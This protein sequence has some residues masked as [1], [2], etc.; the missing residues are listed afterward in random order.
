MDAALVFVIVEET[1]TGFEIFVDL[2]DRSE[3]EDVR[4]GIAVVFTMA[5][6]GTALAFLI[7]LDSG[8]STP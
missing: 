4:I 1:E 2:H 7:P 6:V 3:G 5:L 8:E